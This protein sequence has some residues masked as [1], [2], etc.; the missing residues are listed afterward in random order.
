M[1]SIMKK[2]QALAL[3]KLTLGLFTIKTVGHSYSMQTKKT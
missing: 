2:Q 1:V 3:S